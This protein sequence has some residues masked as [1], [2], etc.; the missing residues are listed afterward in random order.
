MGV[1]HGLLHGG[2]D[3]AADVLGLA[4]HVDLAVGDGGLAEGHG[5][6]HVAGDALGGGG[7]GAGLVEGLGGGSGGGGR[8]GSGAGLGA[9]AENAHGCHAHRAGG[10]AFDKVSA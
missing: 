4:G 5:D 3:L 2:A 9:A 10:H 8:S 1:Q 7:V 6:L